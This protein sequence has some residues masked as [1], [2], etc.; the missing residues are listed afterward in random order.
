MKKVAITG[1]YAVGKS[2]IIQMLSDV[3]Y[4]VFDADVYVSKL[5]EDVAFQNVLVNEIEGL[6]V[7]DKE[8]LAGILY[9]N[10]EI[11]KKLESIIHPMVIKEINRIVQENS[12]EKIIFCEIPLL[13][14]AGLTNEFDVSISIFCDENKRQLRAKE[15]QNYSQ[16]KYEKLKEIQLSQESKKKYADYVINSGNERAKIKEDIN[17]IIEQI[18]NGTKGN[19]GSNT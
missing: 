16:E 19:K 17:N 7:F 13:F 5:Y 14:E 15:R 8:K 3:G 11:R 9:S 2:S 10:K 1:S 4:M 12:H 18:E 6:E